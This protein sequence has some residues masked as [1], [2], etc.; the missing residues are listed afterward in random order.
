M[1]KRLVFLEKMTRDGSL[2]PLAWYG[3]ALEYAGLGRLDDSLAAFQKLRELHPDYV[4]QYLMCGTMLAKSG[5]LDGAR[6]WLTEGAEQAKAKG[7][8]HALSELN[9][10]I[11]G[12]SVARS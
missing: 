2:D 1:S 3:L 9:D 10:A 4:P 12:I 7:D 8:A 11:A 5:R 6:E